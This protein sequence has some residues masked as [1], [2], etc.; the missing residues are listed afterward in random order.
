[1]LNLLLF[2]IFLTCIGMV[3][4]WVAENPGNVTIH[5][6]DYRVDT[7]FGFLLLLTVFA[8][9]AL[10]Y[11]Y[12]ILHHIVRTPERIK[13]RRRIA[14]YEKGLLA[15]THSVAALAS[16]DHKEAGKHTRRAEKF[17]G[18]TP[19]TLLLSAQVARSQGDD[20]KTHNLLTQ[21]LEHKETEY[22]A[23]RSLSDS[24]STH[25]V[26]AALALAQRAGDINPQGVHKIISLHLRIGQWQQALHA[27]GK[28]TRQGHL[29]RAQSRRYKGLITLE[30]GL[31]SDRAGRTDAALI[32]ARHALKY[33][34]DF[35]PAIA[36]AAR[37]YAAHN[38]PN[39]AI[40][41]I[42]KQ[43]KKSPDAL[44]A[45]AFRMAI[46]GLPKDKQLKLVK[47]LAASR[48]DSRESDML[49]AETAIALH[50]WRMARSAVKSAMAKQDTARAC[51]MMAEIE[52]G[53]Y[54][55]FDA[56]QEWRA[57]AAASA[58]D[59]SWNCNHC[60]METK[61]WSSDCPQCHSFDSLEWKPR[62]MRFVPTL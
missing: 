46:A 25:D 61:E 23:A 53:E 44:L 29:T 50:E 51:M 14:S 17:L 38:Q 34:P 47:K 22:L 27:I 41:L 11:A 6:F 30:Q 2:I 56:A 58:V 24:F 16:S 15:L 59:P 19:L 13:S 37:Q 57:S 18:R 35:S 10:I 1:M 45:E 5:W 9:V 26:P 33:V 21:M 3:G 40:S 28:A 7:S 43:W 8:L 42:S 52:Q 49:L 32:A 20:A 48:P 4:A 39:K 62:V 60:G 31:Q 54:S 36:F 55:D 12:H